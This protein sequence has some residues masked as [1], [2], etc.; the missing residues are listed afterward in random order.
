VAAP[1]PANGIQTTIGDSQA[2][3]GVPY[4]LQQLNDFVRTIAWEFNKINESGNDNNGTQLLNY[5][6]YTGTPTLN[7]MVKSTYAAINIHNFS[8]NKAVMDDVS[9]IETSATADYGES[10]NDLILKLIGKRHDTKM[11]A[12]GEPDNYMQSLIGTLGIDAK[13]V[14]SF[15]KGQENLLLMVTNQRLSVSGVD[16]NEETTNML[17]YQ[18]AYNVSAKIISVMDEIYNVTINQMG[19]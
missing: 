15:K 12:K 3:K 5:E 1:T 13:Q 8:T 19:V 9:L 7:A 2:F 17:K 6:G 14:L 11:F 4:Y 18:Q 10:A 16:L